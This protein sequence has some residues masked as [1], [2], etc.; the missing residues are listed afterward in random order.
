MSK[1]GVGIVLLL[2]GV[3][4]LIAVHSMRPPSGFGEALMMM[5]QGRQSFIPEPLYQILMGGGGILALWGLVK[6]VAGLTV[7]K[8]TES[9]LS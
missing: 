3:V 9:Q 5:G 7:P 2:A 4:V 1:T 6:I 8:P